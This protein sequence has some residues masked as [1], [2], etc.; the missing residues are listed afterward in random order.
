MSGTVELA[1]GTVAVTWQE[2][3]DDA[4]YALATQEL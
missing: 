3:V 4:D 2:H 1:E